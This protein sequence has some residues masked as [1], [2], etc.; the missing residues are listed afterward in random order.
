MDKAMQSAAEMPP[1]DPSK[2]TLRIEFPNGA[3]REF[4]AEQPLGYWLRVQE[5]NAPPEPLIAV[6][7]GGNPAAGGMQ[8]SQEGVPG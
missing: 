8:V 1:A 3:Y 7:F 4:T 2:V 5:S 6:F